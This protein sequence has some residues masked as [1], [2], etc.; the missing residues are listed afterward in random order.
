ME[1]K[2]SIGGIIFSFVSEWNLKAAGVIGNFLTEEQTY[3][4]RFKIEK[5][6]K[7]MPPYGQLL[8]EDAFVRC[9]G[10][11]EELQIELRGRDGM[12]TA[13]IFANRR[14]RDLRYEI[15][16]GFK[17]SEGVL[18]ALCSLS[19]MRR[20]LHGF[21]A[22]LLHSSQ[23][24]VNGKGILFTGPSGVGKTTQSSL[25]EQY[26]HAKKRCND[27][28]VIRRI[29]SE[30]FTFGYFEDGTEPVAYNRRLPLGAVVLLRQ[31]EKN[32]VQ[33]ENGKRALVFLM[34]QI[35]LDIWDKRMETEMM[36]RVMDLLETVPVYELGCRADQ[37]A[38]ECL[39][40]QLMRDGVIT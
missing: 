35:F 23:I 37:G 26:G 33:R 13:M 1:I 9:Y 6:E 17:E 32:S 24:E 39:K 31:E 20:I 5:K 28:T 25:W 30:W 19:P 7:A 12:P 8:G 10:D 11:G 36:W 3:D 15:Y 27:R 40:E 22:F 2:L 16:Y 38:V 34:E 21:D 14:M 29:G 18:G 4:V